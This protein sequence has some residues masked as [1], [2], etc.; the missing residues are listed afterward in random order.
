M[1][2]VIFGQEIRQGYI[3][4]QIGNLVGPQSAEAIKEMIQRASESSTGVFATV[5]ATGR[6][7]SLLK[8]PWSRIPTKPRSPDPPILPTN[9]HPWWVGLVVIGLSVRRLGLEGPAPYPLTW[10]FVSHNFQ[11]VVLAL[12]EYA[13]P[14]WLPK[15]FFAGILLWQSV[16]VLIFRWVTVLSFEQGSLSW[17]FVDAAFAAG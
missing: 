10:K 12:A 11:P 2:G 9:M 17:V 16:T 4:E 5:L 1:I 8:T 13:A 14:S 3:L 15:V 6:A 7:L